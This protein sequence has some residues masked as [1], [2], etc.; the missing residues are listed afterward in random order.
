MN[1]TVIRFVTFNANQRISVISWEVSF[2]AS[3]I[4]NDVIDPVSYNMVELA[5][6]VVFLGAINF[7]GW[8]DEVGGAWG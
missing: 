8:E 5:L 4:S 1:N 7:G 6:E 3:E 2:T